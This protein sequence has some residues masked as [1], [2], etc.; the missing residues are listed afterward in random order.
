MGKKG[1][2]RKHSKIDGLDPSLRE[3]VEQMLL[4][5]ATYGCF[6]SSLWIYFMVSLSELVFPHSPCKDTLTLEKQCAIISL[7]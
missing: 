6:A 5:N 1:A 7:E 3:A 2:N 4:S